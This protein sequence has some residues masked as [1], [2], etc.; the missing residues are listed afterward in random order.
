MTTN[1]LQQNK[2]PSA[3]GI[4]IAT[5]FQIFKWGIDV[6]QLFAEEERA[7]EEYADGWKGFAVARKFA[8]PAM[9]AERRRVHS[10]K[11]FAAKRA[12]LEA[13]QNYLAGVAK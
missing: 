4:S 10:K 8:M 3:P 11:W 9:P 7:T 13:F 5:A 6:G 1:S 2:K 12:S